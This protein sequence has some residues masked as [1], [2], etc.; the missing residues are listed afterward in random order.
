MPNAKEFK[1]PA[2][3]INF[4]MR[5]RLAKLS[6]GVIVSTKFYEDVSTGALWADVSANDLPLAMKTVASV[7]VA[8]RNAGPIPDEHLT[9]R[10]VNV[11]LPVISAAIAAAVVARASSDVT[12]TTPEPAPTEPKGKARA[13][14]QSV[15]D[16]LAV[17]VS[18][19]LLFVLLDSTRVERPDEDEDDTPDE[20]E[21]DAQPH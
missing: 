19:A 17:A 20:H 12:P 6:D 8:S 18:R 2:E 9:E 15:K 3:M 16:E 10:V 4:K 7:E 13:L 5:H 21:T 14:N 1:T 11:A